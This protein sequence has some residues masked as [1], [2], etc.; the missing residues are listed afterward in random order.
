M[1]EVKGRTD[2]RV[3]RRHER[4]DTLTFTV[5]FFGKVCCSFVAEIT[6]VQV[7]HFNESSGSHPVVS[8]K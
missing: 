4:V 7:G 5:T 3:K 2:E 6:R 8:A 1:D